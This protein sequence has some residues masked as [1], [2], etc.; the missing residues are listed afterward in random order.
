MDPTPPLPTLPFGNIRAE[1]ENLLVATINKVDREWPAKWHAYPG[2][3]YIVD[4]VAR[5]T[6][7]THLSLR[8]LCVQDPPRLERKPEFA[9]SAIPV[10]RSLLDSVFLLVFLFED[11][12]ARSM[13]YPKSGW[14]E[15]ADWLGIR[16]P[17]LASPPG[18][19][20]WTV[21]PRR[22]KRREP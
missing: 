13:W 8:Y 1:F 17:T 4:S 5:I 22:W 11:L 12:P 3:K 18:S 19:N 6:N 10:V 15:Q 2:A 7:N 21:S 16:H 9:L 14:R 20:G